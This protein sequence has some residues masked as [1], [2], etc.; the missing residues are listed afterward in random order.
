MVSVRVVRAGL[1]AVGVLVGSANAGVAQVVL[2]GRVVADSTKAP[3]SGVEVVIESTH[4]Q[5][6]TDDDGR[7]VLPGLPGGIGFVLVRKIGYRPVRLK[8]LVF[9]NDTLE[10]TVQLKPAVVE[11]E[12]LEVVATAVPPGMQEYAERRLH[13]MGSYL[14]TE[15]LRKSE[16]RL[17]SDLLRQVRGVAIARDRFGHPFAISNRNR[18]PMAIW[19]DG[20]RTFT[21]GQRQSPTDIDEIPISQLEAVE[22]YRGADTPPELGGLGSSCGTIVLWTRRR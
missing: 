10:V 13:G 8:T 1:V 4:R 12:P 6:K 9:G 20:V 22:V 5:T 19:V 11:L 17:L 18:C 3:I 21:P 16:A 15:L 2:T 14:D 7:F